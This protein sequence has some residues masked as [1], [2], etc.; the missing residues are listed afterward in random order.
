[1]DL[2]LSIWF[3]FLESEYTFVKFS[4]TMHTKTVLSLLL[5]LQFNINCVSDWCA[6]NSVRLNIAKMRVVSYSRE[7]NILS[8]EYQLCHFAIICTCSL[9]DLRF[10]FNSCLS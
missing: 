3:C 1:M 7:K 2:Y 10:F 6:T 8:S 4:I 5:L 9:W